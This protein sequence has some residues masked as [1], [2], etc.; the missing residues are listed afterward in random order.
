[1]LF[2]VLVAVID[3]SNPD[4][5]LPYSPVK[6][7]DTVTATYPSTLDLATQITVSGFKFSSSIL[8]SSLYPT[9]FD[10]TNIV[11]FYILLIFQILDIMYWNLLR[12]CRESVFYTQ[13]QLP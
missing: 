10:V 13:E 2:I 8:P 4:A 11:I 3:F 5:S 1:M 9:C 12:L 7:I 6:L